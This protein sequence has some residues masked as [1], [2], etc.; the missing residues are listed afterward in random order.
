MH[1]DSANEK[2]QIST[3]KSKKSTNNHVTS[4]FTL[5]SIESMANEAKIIHKIDFKNRLS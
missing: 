2:N 1:N 3:K 4:F 5:T